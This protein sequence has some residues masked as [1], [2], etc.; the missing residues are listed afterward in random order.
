[1]SDRSGKKPLSLIQSI[2]QRLIDDLIGAHYG[3]REI[4]DDKL[5]TEEERAEQKK[6]VLQVLD[7]HEREAAD[8]A[9]FFEAL[10]I[11]ADAVKEFVDGGQ[12]TLDEILVSKNSWPFT[13]LSELEGK[14]GKPAGGYVYWPMVE[15]GQKIPPEVAN[16]AINFIR[17]P[18]LF[19]EE[20][21][22][23][24]GLAADEFDVR[25]LRAWLG[26][27]S[28]AVNRVWAHRILV[29]T[30]ILKKDSAPTGPG[31]I[32]AEAEMGSPGSVPSVRGVP[33]VRPEPDPEIAERLDAFIECTLQQ[34]E[35]E[36]EGDLGRVYD[37]L[38]EKKFAVNGLDR[39][40][41][42]RQLERLL[43]HANP[44]VRVSAATYL[45]KCAPKRA[46]PVL[47]K[48]AVAGEIA[49]DQLMDRAS[50]HARQT[51]WA[52]EDGLLDV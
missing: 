45:A 12:R 36:A 7:A 5:W 52:H 34:Y 26:R 21:D 50:M 14:F 29:D 19:A 1:M 42:R 35:A 11:D 20:L 3:N 31:A 9:M 15:W 32:S 10:K 24:Y 13:S 49:G 48:M 27:F 44:A 40:Q 6:R 47:E 17:I 46:L 16:D 43:N 8:N 28:I 23:R 41:K 4:G 2:K 37:C 30:G 51:L 25:P 38:Q 33:I 39:N 22:Q 18:R